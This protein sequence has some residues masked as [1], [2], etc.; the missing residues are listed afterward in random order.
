MSEGPRVVTWDARYREDFARLNRGWIEQH[1]QLE[2]ADVASFA[3]P[4]GTFVATGG[5]VFF[6]LSGGKVLGT[7]ALRRE[8]D[9]VYELCKMAVDPEARGLGLG[10]ALMEAVLRFA[11]SHAASRVYLV[12]NTKLGPALGLYRKH[13]FVTTREGEEVSR[14]AGYARADIEMELRLG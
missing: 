1:F 12:S 5:E 3:D 4:H 6:A 2:P 10:D 14:E 13:G 11:K 7:C 9:G 8:A